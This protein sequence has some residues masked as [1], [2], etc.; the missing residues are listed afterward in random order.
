MKI[1]VVIEDHDA[2]RVRWLLSFGGSNPEEGEFIEL[3]E[4]QCFWLQDKIRSLAA[5]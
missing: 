1:P 2:G 5:L 3:T 4:E